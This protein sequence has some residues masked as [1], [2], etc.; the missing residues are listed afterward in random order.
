MANPNH[1]DKGRFSSS[2]SV[3]EAV[4]SSVS[5]YKLRDKQQE[6]EEKRKGLKAKLE[7]MGMGTG[8][9]GMTPDHI[10]AKPE[11]QKLK[12]EHDAHWA[13]QK[14]LNEHVA[15]NYPKEQRDERDAKRAYVTLKASGHMK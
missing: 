5:Y 11:Y 6:M 14:K 13:E 12:A 2:G 8:P 1:D 9:M 7:S 10:K 4:V 15:K 3:R